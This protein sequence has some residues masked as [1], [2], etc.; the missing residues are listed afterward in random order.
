MIRRLIALALLVTSLPLAAAGL[1]I[2]DAW[3]KDLPAAVPMRAGYMSITNSGAM[4]RSIVSLSSESFMHIDIH[5]SIEK[6]GMISMQPVHAFSIPP[7]KS[8]QLAP[9]GFHLMM[10]NPLQPLSLGDQISVTLQFD[11]QSTQII[12]MVVRK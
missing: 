4:E 5:Q 2:T 3:I 1:I 9:G 11:D 6:D 10:M 7:G 12:Q 8:M